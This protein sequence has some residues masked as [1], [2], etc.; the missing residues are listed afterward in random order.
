MHGS[1]PST[2]S[3]TRNFILELTIH[4]PEKQSRLYFPVLELS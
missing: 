1:E 4:C 3:V 2:E